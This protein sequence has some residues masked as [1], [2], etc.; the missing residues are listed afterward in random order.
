MFTCTPL[1]FPSITGAGA[2]AAAAVGGDTL[3]LLI[4]TELVA[5]SRAWIH[6]LFDGGIVF[7]GKFYW[8][9]INSHMATHAWPRSEDLQ[10]LWHLLVYSPRP[11]V[12]Q[13]PQ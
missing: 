12:W 7:D 1:P 9:R 13:L 2:G 4:E 6:T 8:G 10:Q 3:Q 5:T 11:E